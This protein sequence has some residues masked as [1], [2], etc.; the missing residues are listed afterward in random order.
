MYTNGKS[1]RSVGLKMQQMIKNGKKQYHKK[2]SNPS[3]VMPMYKKDTNLEF[4]LKKY[5]ITSSKLLK[6]K[7]INPKYSTAITEIPKTNINED[8][9]HQNQIIQENEMELSFSLMDRDE[10]CLLYT[11]TSFRIFL[12]HMKC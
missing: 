3:Y 8:P 5:D 9:N 6:G 4:Q 1:N 2:T 10:V 12:V 7:P 11:L